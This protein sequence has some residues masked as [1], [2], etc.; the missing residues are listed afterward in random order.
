RLASVGQLAAGIAHEVRNPLASI[1]GA[2]QLLSGGEKV[3]PDERALLEIVQRETDR[4]ERL[5]ASFLSYARPT[6]RGHRPVGVR[7]LI[8]V[9]L[10]MFENDPA[11]GTGITCRV[12][13]LE[14]E[15]WVTGDADQLKQVLWNLLTNAAQAMAG[16]WG[17]IRVG[18]QRRPSAEEQGKS[19]I[20][21]WV[22]DEGHGMS[23]ELQ[24]HIFDP[25]FTTRSTGTGLG[26][27]T[28]HR[29]VEEHGGVIE[30]R[31]SEGQGTRM[32]FLLK[33]ARPQP[34][35]ASVAQS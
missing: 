17:T 2:V 30:V 26:L 12:E 13:E 10:R 32:A 28:V 16:R 35:A 25:F 31:S 19:W 22:E 24:A 4:L 33:E 3:S 18:A 9:T 8:L 11:L 14:E 21:V 29:I 6:S 23:E 1:S 34:L 27:A 5:I 7:E 20:E 15:L